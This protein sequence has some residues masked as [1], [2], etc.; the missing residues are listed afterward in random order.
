MQATIIVLAFPPN[1][2]FN[3]L[4]SLLSRYGICDTVFFLEFS[5]KVLMQFPKA[6]RLRLMLAPSC[7]F[8]LEF[9]VCIFSEPAK[10]MMNS[11]DD[12]FSDFL[13]SI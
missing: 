13:F 2:S 5:A 7:I 11:L 4:V 6:K 1:E 12:S 3:S 10:S 9:R 8:L